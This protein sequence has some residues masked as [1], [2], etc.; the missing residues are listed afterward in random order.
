M[1]SSPLVKFEL[2]GSLRVA[3]GPN[4][5]DV[6]LHALDRSMGA[7]LI[8]LA[9]PPGRRVTSVALS[10][11]VGRVEDISTVSG[12]ISRVRTLMM[13]ALTEHGVLDSEA[14]EELR[15]TL[16]P[17]C[18]GSLLDG[19]YVLD[20]ELVEVDASDFMEAV[21]DINDRGGVDESTVQA[22]T[23]ALNLWRGDPRADLAEYCNVN[24]LFAT[25]LGE[26]DALLERTLSY[27]I[28][29][30]DVDEARSLALR[31]RRQNPTVD[32][33]GGDVEGIF[34]ELLAVKDR[35]RR[36]A[37]DEVV[38]AED[39]TPDERAERE[40]TG[41]QRVRL[42]GRKLKPS[43]GFC[44][45]VLSG[46]SGVGKDTLVG[47]VEERLDSRYDLALLRKYTTRSRRPREHPYTQSISLEQYEEMKQR[48][49]FLLEY[50]K[51]STC[52]GFDLDHFLYCARTGTPTLIVLGTQTHLVPQVMSQ[53]ETHGVLAASIYMT[54]PQQHLSRRAMQRNFTEDQAFARITSIRRD[55]READLRPE[56]LE[57][58]DMVLRNGDD[59]ALEDAAAQLISFV[60]SFLDRR[61]PL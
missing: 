38:R 48:G 27:L 60:S 39:A 47:Y 25:H 8:M 30:D 45:L 23:T 28:E 42:P 6:N 31:F 33:Y 50:S 9:L 37:A 11:V 56:F 4:H 41:T 44:T 12:A 46:P 15:Y 58:Q 5:H 34:G 22:A 13:S 10:R 29:A 40:G 59:V 2:L 26:R 51:F 21:A 18:R 54:A 24:Q 7:A 1:I 53:F 19:T 17:K 55:C 3:V 49:E 14:A 35:A 20:P 57:S 32:A 43:D 36:D 16:V 52:Y 61:S